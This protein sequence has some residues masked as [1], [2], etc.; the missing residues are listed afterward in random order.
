MMNLQQVL[1][2]FFHL[3]ANGSVEIYNEFSLQHE[4]GCYIRSVL[5]PE[6]KVQFERPTEFFG[7]EHRA[8]EKK[9]IDIVVFS[10]NRKAAIELKFPRNGQYPEQMFEACRDIR[11]LEQLCDAG[12]EQG[13]FV[14]V[15]DDDG[16]YSLKRQND[17]IYRFFR[18]G[19]P[20]RG[21]IRK[22]TG[23]QNDIL[24]FRG[25]YQITWSSIRGRLRYALVLVMQNSG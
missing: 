25:T 13:L 4:I 19:Y 7:I 20:L 5:S 12:F 11:F 17:G 21:S 18:A 6:F 24:T 1:H 16:F 22:P 3:V 10:E 14:M 23:S 8:L 2:D 9:E 15:A